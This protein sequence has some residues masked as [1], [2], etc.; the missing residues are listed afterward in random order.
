MNLFKKALLYADDIEAISILG[1]MA[2]ACAKKNLF[3]SSFYFFQKAFDKIKPGITENELIDLAGAEAIKGKSVE[4]VA[5]LVI[6]KGDVLLRQ[7]KISKN[8]LA[9]NKAIN[10]YKLADRLL[11][12]VKSMQ[13]EPETKLFWREHIKPLYE[14]AIEASY[15]SGNPESGFYFFE[16]SRAVLLNDQLN[17]QHWIAEKDIARRS[18]VENEIRINEK[19]LS[20]LDKSSARFSELQNQVFEKRQELERLQE[21]VKA[22]SP[23]YYQNF[24]DTNFIT[25]KNVREILFKDHQALVELF[26][27]DSAVYLFYISSKQTVLHKIDKK[28][29]DG[30]SQS[31]TRFLSSFPLLNKNFS[32]F[33][34]VSQQLY[35]LMFADIELP[36]GRIIISPDGEYFPFEALITKP[37]SV[38]YFLNDFAVSYTYSARWLLNDFGNKSTSTGKSFL[39]VAPVRFMNGLPVLSGSDESLSRIQNLFSQSTMLIAGNATKKNF[40]DQFANYRIIQLYTHSAFNRSMTEPTIYFADSSLTISELFYGKR[41]ATSL[42]FLA[43]CETALGDLHPGEGVFSF[44]RAFAALGIPSAV[45]NLWEVDS[46]SSYKLTELFYKY[47]AEGL[48]LDV[49]L[50]KAKLE[51]LSMPGLENKLPYFWSAPILVGQ[52]NE[53]TFEKSSWKW[54]GLVALLIIIAFWFDYRITGNKKE[55][56]GKQR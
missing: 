12:R 1:Y 23:L 39:G 28:S 33:S 38:N 10:V 42:V 5:R 29:F 44:N 54:L 56:Q 24:V 9:L 20:Q 50:Q 52:T 27:G 43:A 41:P 8:P 36:H 25:V 4:Y 31:F 37:G 35:Q 21:Q 40:I 53:I 14:S 48:P 55:K 18:E 7:Y 15:L 19:E 51:Y 13:L 30:L 46:R 49:S 32:A 6:D 22:N 16:K 47:V 26:S 17:E 2:K 11:T 3:D 34:E 45:S